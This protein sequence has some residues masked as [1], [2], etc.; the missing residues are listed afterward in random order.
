MAKRILIVGNSD[1]I[2]AATTAA[3]VAR[4]ESVVGVSRSP[5]SLKPPARGDESHRHEVM[6]VTDPAYPALLGR[7]VQ[8]SGPFDAC[9]YCVGVGSELELSDLSHEAM[10]FEVNLTAM[11]RT[12]EILLP[13]WLERGAGH[14][15]GLSSMADTLISPG[16]PSYSASKA[17]FSNYLLGMALRL[18]SHGIAV[19]NVRFGFVDTKMAKGVRKPLMMTIDRAAGHLLDCLETRPIQLSRP[20]VAA[21]GV[22]C[23]RWLQTVHVWWS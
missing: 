9:I 23:A 17:G 20:S 4:G 15:I 13:P 10:V 14:F 22:L 19:T 6:D 12:L 18:R 21:A 2:G 1:G 3:L 7:L 16:A 5:S 11:V 8:E